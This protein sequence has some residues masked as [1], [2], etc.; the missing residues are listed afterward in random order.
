VI[1]LVAA[2]VYSSCRRTLGNSQMKWT[3]VVPG[4]TLTSSKAAS[5]VKTGIHEAAGDSRVLE[6]DINAPDIAPLM[7]PVRA[8]SN[9]ELRHR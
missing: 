9:T 8:T 1:P 3:Y 5:G 2:M 7:Q 6:K 4:L